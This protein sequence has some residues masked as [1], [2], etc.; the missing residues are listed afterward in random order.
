MAGSLSNYLANKDLD[1][2]FGG[3]DFTRP[4]TVYLA[5][6]T[7]TP[8]DAGGGTPVS[9]ADYA[10]LAITNNPTNFPAASGRHKTNGVDLVY[11]EA[12]NAWGQIVAWALFDAVTAGNI[13]AWGACTQQQNIT[14]GSAAKFK[15]GDLDIDVVAGS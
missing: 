9:A 11:P 2:L 3:G 1:H 8:N 5:I 6:Y 15:A 4:A 7:A 10:R 14:V 13:L 12:T